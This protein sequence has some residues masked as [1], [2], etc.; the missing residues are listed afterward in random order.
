MDSPEKP[1]GRDEF[2]REPYPCHPCLNVLYRTHDLWGHYKVET[3]LFFEVRQLGVTQL[4]L[5]KDSLV[6]STFMCMVSIA[7][8]LLS[9]GVV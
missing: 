8:T 4:V 2:G 3:K 6:L 7:G 9:T 1:R 5:Q